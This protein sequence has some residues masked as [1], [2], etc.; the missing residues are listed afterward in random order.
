MCFYFLMME[1]VQLAILSEGCNLTHS[2]HNG[3]RFV[4]KDLVLLFMF[5]VLISNLLNRGNV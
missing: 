4:V 2:C 5:L 1:N 3:F